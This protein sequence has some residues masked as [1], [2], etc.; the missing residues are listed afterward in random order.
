VTALHQVLAEIYSSEESARRVAREA[1]IDVT[2]VSWSPRMDDTWHSI[3]EEARQQ[4]LLYDL[5]EV[6]QRQYPRRDDLRLA[7]EEDVPGDLVT[8][9]NLPLEV[10]RLKQQVAT[11]D[12]LLRRIMA[13]IDPGPRK[14]TAR[15]I[16]YAVLIALWSS[17]MI[18]P[19][20]E[21][22]FVNPV[23]AAVVTAAAIVVAFVVRW[24]PEADNGQP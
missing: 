11:H 13:E 8:H 12:T 17:W 18:A 20:R 24:L 5:V 15:A 9:A 1:G 14:R 3:V 6:A 16:F 22:Y 4:T 19:I 23:P 2:H 10:G 7:A 21:W